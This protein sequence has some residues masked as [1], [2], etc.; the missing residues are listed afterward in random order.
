MIERTRAAGVPRASS[1]TTNN[2]NKV[3]VNQHHYLNLKQHLL[4]TR[5]MMQLQFAANIMIVIGIQIVNM[6]M[7]AA[8][9][10]QVGGGGTKHMP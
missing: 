7:K 1:K 6:K 5:F 2:K 3:K 4:M 10:L 9:N 8:A